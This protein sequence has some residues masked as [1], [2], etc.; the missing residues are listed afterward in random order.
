[1]LVTIA[2]LF[3]SSFLGISSAQPTCS[4][5]EMDFERE[6]GLLTPIEI[7]HHLESDIDFVK[8]SPPLN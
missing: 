5:I 3:C 1:M 7:K 6:K 2:G 8:A 4:Q